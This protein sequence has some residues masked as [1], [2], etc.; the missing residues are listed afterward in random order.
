MVTIRID[1]VGEQIAGSGS[2]QPRRMTIHCPVVACQVTGCPVNEARAGLTLQM[3]PVSWPAMQLG[4]FSG[5]APAS[6]GG[7]ADATPTT[8][9]TASSTTAS[10]GRK[11]IFRYVVIAQT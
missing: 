7:A 5:D 3:W 4:R 9:R 6:L 2:I 8:P 10:T 1:W 11:R